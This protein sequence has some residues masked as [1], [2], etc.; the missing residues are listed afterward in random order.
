[1]RYRCYVF[2]IVFALFLVI[3]R[4]RDAK[5][6][7]VAILVDLH[8]AKL[9]EAMFKSHTVKSNAAELDPNR[10]F[11]RAARVDG[12][13]ERVFDDELFSRFLKAEVLLVDLFLLKFRNLK[14][15]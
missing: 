14:W 6:G 11:A 5:V 8:R 12:A 15:A 13:I 7:S 3:G 10:A 9:R 1:M 4:I 2:N